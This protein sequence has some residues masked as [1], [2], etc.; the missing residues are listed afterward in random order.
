[1]TVAV[2][3]ELLPGNPKTS[4]C[5][6][7]P[8][9]KHPGRCRG[10]RDRGRRGRRARLWHGNH[11]GRPLEDV[12]ARGEEHIGLVVWFGPGVGKGLKKK[13]QH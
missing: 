4:L 9:V 13:E 8:G 1:M 5:C 7:V 6:S 3:D 10:R 2:D 11:H 12:V